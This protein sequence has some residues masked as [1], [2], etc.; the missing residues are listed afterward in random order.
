MCKNGGENAGVRRPGNE[1][2][3]WLLDIFHRNVR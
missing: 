2:K 1:A 3:M